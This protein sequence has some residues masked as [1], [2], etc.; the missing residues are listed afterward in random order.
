MHAVAHGGLRT[1]EYDHGT[2]P[3]RKCLRCPMQFRRCCAFRKCGESKSRR[4]PAVLARM[5][6]ED[7]RC[8]EVEVKARRCGK[9]VERVG[10]NHGR[11]RL[12][13]EQAHDQLR[14]GMSAAE[15][16]TDRERRSPRE[17]RIE[18]GCAAGRIKF[19]RRVHRQRMRRCALKSHERAR[20]Q[21]RRERK[22]DETASAAEGGTC[23][24]DRT[25][26]HDAGARIASV[27]VRAE[28]HRA[29]ADHDDGAECAL[30]AIAVTRRERRKR[31]ASIGLRRRAQAAHG[32]VP[33][34]TGFPSTDSTETERLPTAVTIPAKTGSIDGPSCAPVI[35]RM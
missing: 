1:L 18:H 11:Q 21:R 23:T 27:W 17:H 29:P 30:V 26:E 9:R 32:D 22:V 3:L 2:N 7:R 16:W 35:T 15:P 5:R 33:R 25:S 31:R 20:H 10:V 6:G 12:A 13:R 8:A 34:G 14:N 4:E 28:A 19:A 24:E